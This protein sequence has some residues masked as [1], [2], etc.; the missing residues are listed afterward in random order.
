[1]KEKKGLSASQK[2]LFLGWSAKEKRAAWKELV[3]RTAISDHVN[4]L[5]VSLLINEYALKLKA[6][7][8]QKKKSVSLP[9]S[10]RKKRVQ[11]K[12]NTRTKL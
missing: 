3:K 5:I 11:I 6:V 9:Q 1:M 4:W 8:V 2:P 12:Q 10:K 7:K